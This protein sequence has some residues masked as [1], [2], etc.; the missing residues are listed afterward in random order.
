MTPPLYPLLLE[1]YL[2]P[3]LWG[4]QRLHGFLGLDH[5]VNPNSDPI[6]E[7]WQVYSENCI[8]N[9][10]W[11]GQRLA[12]LAQAQPTDLLGTVSLAR[13]GAKVP[14]LAKFIDAAAPLSIQVHPDDSYA[15]RVEAASGHLGKTEA[16]YILEAAPDAHIIWGFKDQLSPAQLREAIAGGSLEQHVNIVPVQAGDVIYNPAGTLHAI[17]AGILLFEIQQSS[18]LTYRLYDYQ[19]RDSQGRLRELH[20][21]KALDVLNFTPSQSAKCLAQPLSA[22]ANLRKTLLLHCEAFVMEHWQL[23]GEVQ[24]ATDSSSLRIL[25]VCAGH[26]QLQ[27]EG[28]PPLSLQQGSSVLLPAA[29]GAYQLRGALELVCCYVPEPR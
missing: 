20:V 19:R 3:R 27:Q 1:P 16:W 23:Q 11:A 6:G 26:G 28:Q 24:E 2:S 5:P 7:A 29:L 21:D 4:G 15:K 17:G 13:Y 22:T 14:L 10:A 25:T 9:G 8:R 12:D 18:D